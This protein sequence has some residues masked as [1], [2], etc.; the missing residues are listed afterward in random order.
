MEAE[1]TPTNEPEFFESHENNYDVEQNKVKK[2]IL[3]PKSMQD[4]MQEQKP[5]LETK[6]NE[7]IKMQDSSMMIKNFEVDFNEEE[8]LT[9]AGGVK[10]IRAL[11][12]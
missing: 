11:R 7:T 6:P 5:Y 4:R 8:E 12:V 9:W 2:K 10:G 3:V 1:F